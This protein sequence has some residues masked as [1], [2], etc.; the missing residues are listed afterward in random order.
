MNE[1]DQAMKA[2]AMQ[3]KAKSQVVSV[4]LTLIFGPLGLFYS[5]ITGGLLMLIAPF[6]AFGMMFSGNDGAAAS[7]FLFLLLYWFLCVV[8]GIIA[9]SRYN[10]KL[11]SK[12]NN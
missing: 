12:F 3:I 6:L 10:S 1:Q 11:I 9:T 7:G 5:T 4:L 8:W 2:A